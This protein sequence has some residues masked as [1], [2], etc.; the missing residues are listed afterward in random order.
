MRF[1]YSIAVFITALAA[2]SCAP[3]Y[4]I[5]MSPTDLT[6]KDTLLMEN[7]TSFPDVTIVG[8]GAKFIQSERDSIYKRNFNEQV[9]SLNRVQGITVDTYV[10]KDGREQIKATL[11]GDLLFAFND[12]QLS[13][14]AQSILVE[15]AK[16][17]EGE[18]LLI[19]GHTDNVGD[20]KY[21]ELLSISR[22]VV[23][24]T[25][26]EELG[27]AGEINT[28]GKG[29]TQPLNGNKTKEEMAKNRRVEIFIYKDGE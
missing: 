15:F 6:S 18:P 19:V 7:N 2:S 10:D 17:L 13:A 16:A 14:S 21:N 29:M 1:I 25:Y 27:Y 9:G 26:L 3:K 24:K 5:Q 12:A 22:A 8:G 23:V 28:Q 11:D 20:V 4:F